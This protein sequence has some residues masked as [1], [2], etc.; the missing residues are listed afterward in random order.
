MKTD[1]T[2][3]AQERAELERLVANRNT[4]AKMG[5]VSRNFRTFDFS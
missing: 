5:V 1:I 4:P 2:I 3:T